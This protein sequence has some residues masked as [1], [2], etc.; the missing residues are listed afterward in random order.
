MSLKE[1]SMVANI[2]FLRQTLNNW[3]GP[4]DGYA[5]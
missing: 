3:S 2:K 4:F 5:V 1:L